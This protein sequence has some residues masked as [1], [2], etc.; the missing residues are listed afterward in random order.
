MAEAGY[1]RGR[2]FQSAAAANQHGDDAG[3][4]IGE[5]PVLQAGP[6]GQIGGKEC[7]DGHHNSREWGW[8]LGANHLALL[9]TLHA[10]GSRFVS[11]AL[12]LI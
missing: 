5:D 12:C 3:G 7:K 4:D 8:S 9:R 1:A 6:D 10:A 2:C 11:A